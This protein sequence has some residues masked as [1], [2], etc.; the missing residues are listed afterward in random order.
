MGGLRELKIV[1]A[2]IQAACLITAQG[3]NRA[4][5]T[6]VA[7][8]AA[9]QCGVSATPA[10]VGQILSSLGIGTGI[11]HGKRQYLLDHNELEKIRQDI[12]GKCQSLAERLESAIEAF[13]ELPERIAGLEK[14]WQE[15]RRLTSLERELIQTISHN[16]QTVA[17][18][19]SLQ[20]QAKQ[21]QQQA[22]Q[23]EVLE[24]EC[25]DLSKKVRSLP[26]L[27]ERKAK[28]EAALAQYGQEA[29]R[30][31]GEEANLAQMIEALKWRRGWATFAA[32]Q[33]AINNANQ[34]LAEITRQINEKRSFLDRILGRNRGDSK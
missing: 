8:L 34:E 23:V 25:R 14:Q 28:L 24:K 22:A 13:R 4:T 1:L 20:A 2:L 12:S 27:A 9:K 19:S 29:D 6:E 17:R 11:S 5:A 16:Q 26:A 18:L 31:Q 15:I 33:Q 21:L 7:R 10:K 32:M 30:L 3:N